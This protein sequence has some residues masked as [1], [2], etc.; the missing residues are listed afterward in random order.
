MRLKYHARLVRRGSAL[1]S[2]Q[3]LPPSSDRYKPDC[4]ASDFFTSD[5][6]TSMSAYTRLRSGA[7]STPTRPQSPS[8]SP[9]PPRRVHVLPASCERK[10]PPPGPSIGAYVL[11]GGRRVCHVPANK[12]CGAEAHI[13]KSE[14][15][16][17][18]SKPRTRVQCAPP[19][20]DL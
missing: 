5:F 13:A 12:S 11:H 17:P 6:F 9:F 10:R 15:P 16:I 18:G 20:T 8:G 4:F 1:A 3:V 14:M 19:S 7:T 2:T